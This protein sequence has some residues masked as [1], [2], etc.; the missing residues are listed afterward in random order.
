M[1][2]PNAT[3]YLFLGVG[4]TLDW[5]IEE[6]FGGGSPYGWGLTTRAE[7][8]GEVARCGFDAVDE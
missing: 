4:L 1:G 5:R 2:P 7:T 6:A 3:V 8:G